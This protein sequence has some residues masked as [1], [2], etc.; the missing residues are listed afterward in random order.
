MASFLAKNFCFGAVGEEG[1][2]RALPGFGE[3][4][5]WGVISIGQGTLGPFAEP[6]RP[7]HSSR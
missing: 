4:I 2:S 6:W 3:T 1:F 7:N 5:G